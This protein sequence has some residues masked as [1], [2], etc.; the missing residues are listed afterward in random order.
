V[1]SLSLALST[2]FHLIKYI[3]KTLFIIYFGK[4][5]SERLLQHVN[6]NNI[7]VEEQ[8]GF[9]PATSTDKASYRLINEMLNAMNERKVMEASSVTYARCLIVLT[10]I[11]Y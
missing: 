5:I 2:Q 7:L 11:S 6:I 3:K 10:V 9:R 1:F 4:I 8:F